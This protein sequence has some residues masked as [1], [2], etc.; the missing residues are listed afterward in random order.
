MAFGASASRRRR[1]SGTSANP[2]TSVQTSAPFDGYAAAKRTASMP[3]APTADARSCS[4]TAA[5]CR[6]RPHSQKTW[7]TAQ[8][9]T[10]QA[11]SSKARAV[12]RRF[13]RTQTSAIVLR[14]TAAPTGT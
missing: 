14:A 4:F 10:A 5:G 1:K 13:E 7:S 12:S 2:A 3:P 9:K 11:T 8:A 6:E